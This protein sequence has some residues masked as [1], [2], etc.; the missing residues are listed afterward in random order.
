VLLSRR[1]G[2]HGGLLAIAIV[3]VEIVAVGSLARLV[4]HFLKAS[5]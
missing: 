3:I 4:D 1:V 2:A 5:R